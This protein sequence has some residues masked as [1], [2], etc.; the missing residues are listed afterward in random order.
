MFID[1]DDLDEESKEELLEEAREYGISEE[2]VIEKF[3]EEARDSANALDFFDNE[4]FLEDLLRNDSGLLEDY[5][6]FV[7]A[8]IKRHLFTQGLIKKALKKE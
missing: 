5:L 8:K 1:F 2:N 7:S 6:Y 4:C 3:N